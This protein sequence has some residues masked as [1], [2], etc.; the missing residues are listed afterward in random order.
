[1][2][3]VYLC[4]VCVVVAEAVIVVTACQCVVCVCVCVFS[5]FFIRYA[6]VFAEHMEVPRAVPCI[7][8]V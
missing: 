7:R 8:Y 6:H 5:K 2:G 4:R 1:M 3:A